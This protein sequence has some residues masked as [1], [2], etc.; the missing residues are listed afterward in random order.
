LHRVGF[1]A[2]TIEIEKHFHSIQNPS[3]FHVTG[4]GGM[5]NGVM[6][7]DWLSISAFWDPPSSYR[8]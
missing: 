4:V 2:V 8:L 6:M 5:D 3:V 1:I 7:D